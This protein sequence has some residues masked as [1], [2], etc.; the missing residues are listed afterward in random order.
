LSRSRDERGSNPY[1]WLQD[2][3]PDDTNILD[4]A[5]GSAPWSVAF[6]D[7]WF[8]FDRSLA[9]LRLAHTRGA[10]RIAVGD[11]TAAPFK[12]ASADAVVCAMALMLVQPLD[13]G[14]REIVRVLRPR[15]R[16]VV[17]LPATRPLRPS[18][19]MRYLRLLVALRRRRL[20]YPNDRALTRPGTQLSEAGLELVDDAQRRFDFPIESAKTAG[21][22][23]DSLYL[24]GTDD[25]R[26]APARA[27]AQRWIGTTMGIPLRR[28]VAV[29]R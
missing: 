15:G 23:V 7:R 29:R 26:L 4:I 6:A 17:L 14:L 1:E 11:A 21:E 13:R 18:D 16:L 20:G 25:A 22:F 10:Q 27:E 24:P 2:A 19:R 3:V 9:E 28:L 12:R 5:C 8:G